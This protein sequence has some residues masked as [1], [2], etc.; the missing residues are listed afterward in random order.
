M[1]SVLSPS[2]EVKLRDLTEYGAL[3]EGPSLPEGT[4]FQI[5]YRGQTIYGFVVWTEHDRFGARFPFAL[6]EGPLHERLEQARIEHEIHR[7]GGHAASANT[8]GAPS[9]PLPTFGRRG[10]N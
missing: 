6:C 8:I 10:L 1:T 3:I 2:S 9:R 4:Q 7:R 5:E